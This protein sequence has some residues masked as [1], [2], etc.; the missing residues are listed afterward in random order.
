MVEDVPRRTRLLGVG[1][2]AYVLN[3]SEEEAG[4]L[5]SGKSVLSHEQREVLN[6]LEQFL[7]HVF[8]RRSSNIVLEPQ[9]AGRLTEVG[10]RNGRSF[11]SELRAKLGGTT[12]VQEFEDDVQEAIAR[13]CDECFP[14][15]LLPVSGTS[16]HF[17]RME[18]PRFSGTTAHED[19]MTAVRSDA[20]L[21]KLFPDGAPDELSWSPHLLSSFGRGRSVQLCLL[22]EGVIEA[23]VAAMHAQG[24]SSVSDLRSATFEMLDALRRIAEGE[25]IDLPVIDTFDLLGLPN[26]VEI[27]VRDAK[28]VG[29]PREFLRHVPAVARPGKRGEMVLGCMLERKARFSA[30]PMNPGSE[31]ESR[32]WP[33]ECTH[34]SAG[35]D[36]LVALATGLALDGE[37]FIAARRRS[38]ITIDPINGVSPSWTS[39]DGKP[40]HDHLATKEECRRLDEL[41]RSLESV[42][43]GRIH[44]A[45]NRFLKAMIGRAEPEDS[46]IDA[47]IGLEN[48]FG[49]R[50]EAAFSMA[51]GVSRL[52][53]KDRAE[54]EKV[55]SKIKK[56]YRARS[57]VV[58]GREIKRQD[59]VSLLRADALTFL[60]R[61]LVELLMN[62]RDL[63]EPDSA[64]RV[65]ALVLGDD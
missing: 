28:L 24:R 20:S 16:D 57:D 45:V 21:T 4:A 9:D 43:L 32:G 52:L 54:R 27:S 40:L 33:V 17:G 23:G 36:K 60:K 34:S 53:G 3:T 14:F 51:S 58:H 26:D 44:V 59:D 15:T 62:R 31:G 22:H 41:T 46:L 64:G 47:V 2:L 38:T 10:F 6:Q 48:L 8:Q 49:G 55:F 18:L 25:D 63:L 1:M 50:T 42:D 39:F 13:M 12:C 5:D 11:F 61:C 7:A 30:R 29:M 19:F 56:V 35:S 37:S 65:Q